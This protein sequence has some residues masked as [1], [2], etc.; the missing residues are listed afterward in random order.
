MVFLYTDE[1]SFIMIPRP[2]AISVLFAVSIA[3]A[4]T[5]SGFSFPSTKHT[6]FESLQIS[7]GLIASY[8]FDQPSGNILTDLSGNN[9]HGTLLNNPTWTTG[10]YD[11]ALNF[12]GVNDYVTIGDLDLPGSFTVSFWSTADNLGGGC[13]GSAVMKRND[14]GFEVCDGKMLAQVGT[15]TGGFN[16]ALAYQ[17]PQSGV[18]NYYALTYDGTTARFYV[19][20]N[21]TATT[22]KSHGSNNNPL[23]IGSWNTGSEFYDGLID[24]VRIYTRTLSQSE[25][26]SD[27]NSPVNTG[28]EV[29]TPHIADPIGGAQVSNIITVIAH[30]HSNVNIES[31]QFYVDGL[32]TGPEDATDPYAL[33]WDTREVANGSHTLTASAR[34]VNGNVGF[35]ETVTVNVVNANY[36]QNEILATGFNLPTSIEFLPD[37][38]ML[39]VELTGTIKILPHPYTQSNPTPFLQLNLNIGGYDG[40]QQGIYDLVL[41][42]DFSNNHY[43]YIFYTTGGQNRY[44]RLSR[45]TANSSITGTLPGSEVVLYQDPQ[46]ADTEHH[47]GS[48]N[49]GNDGKIYFTTG[50]HF[51]AAVAQL[52]S[53]PRGKIHRINSDGSVPTDNPF[54]DASGPNWDSI[55]ALGLRNPFRAYYDAP[56][57]R[58]LVADVGGNVYSTAKEEINLGIA[59]ANYG[60]P[61]SEGNCSS[62]C[63]SPIYFYPHNGRDASTSGGFVYHGAQFPSSY[64]DNYFFADY[65]QNWIRRLTFDQN[66]NVGG[67]YNFEPADGSLDG[68]YGDIVYLTEGPDGA[69]YYVDL[70]YSDVGGTF[71]ISKIRRIRYIETNQAP[72]AIA[73]GS[74]TAGP[75]PLLVNFSSVGSSDPE[76]ATLAY[77]WTF[78]DGTTSTEANPTHTYSQ[79]GQYTVRLSVSDGVNS[80]LAPPIFISAGNKPTGTILT[81]QDGSSFIAGQIITFSGSGTD[82]EDG[83]LPASAFTWNIDFLHE[84][85]AHPGLVMNGSKSGTFTIPTNGHD[86]S[87]NTRYRITLTITDSTG[88]QDIKSVIVYPNKVNLSFNTSPSGLTLYLDGIAH[89]APFVYDTLVG[90][91]HT[92]D[93]PNQ[94][95]YTFSSW[96]DGGS[97]THV[98][99]VP[100]QNTN[101]LASFNTFS[102]PTA[103][104][105]PTSTPT[106]TATATSTRTPTPS[107]TVTPTSTPTK[108]A[109]ATS[110]R[111]PTPTPALSAITIGETDILA[112]DDSG[113][114]SLLL[115]Q[116]TVLSQSATIQSMSFYVATV[117]GQLRLG[118]YNDAGGGPGTLLAQTAAF[119]PTTGWNTRNVVTPVL[120]P[121]GTYWL[122]Y[123]PESNNL[124]FR[125]TLTGSAKYYSYTFGTLPNTFSGSSTS[126]T[127][128]WSLYATLTT[129]TSPGAG[130]YDDTD[131][132]WTY[133]GTWITASGLTGPHANTFTYSGTAGNSASF[134]F[135]GTQFILKYLQ[136]INRGSIAIYVDGGYVATVNQNGPLEW[137]KTYTSPVYSSG[138]HTVRIDHIGGGPYVDIDA[139]V[140]Q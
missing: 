77:A 82:T 39:V 83:S 28:S 134:S 130:T 136:Y 59:G 119:T 96:S 58:L 60:W 32:P 75:I 55:W 22:V 132:G 127:V 73:T 38:R 6:S 107:A 41:D 67:V 117:G 8:S 133:T 48:I 30:V 79:A 64:Q 108:T 86:F 114:G 120:L 54:Y 124:H 131:G 112:S 2:I 72:I 99:T 78:G 135:T 118:I 125:K 95:P 56:T 90:Y 138:P 106:K 101:Y 98:I 44:D 1:R 52:L 24:E 89:T 137:Q 20:G 63:T 97:Q 116:Q 34:D 115:A 29:P 5:V 80:T 123:L 4:L 91:N 102:T 94:M 68:P 87:G 65:S 140:I 84:G 17:I 16:T 26:Q 33:T 3:L 7:S 81:P 13:H 23:L 15:G 139:I 110:T 37:G 19:N 126:A 31:V 113:N 104:V 25:I 45:F 43:Y 74:P 18:W 61:N 71:G 88:L 53:S 100:A 92:I 111:T 14:Y 70:G 50:D 129:E 40:L 128:H 66:G 76:G 27:M 105:T 69:I 109:T 103:T 62:P 85:H 10:K 51:N 57:S 11:N 49:F 47:G 21:L 93:A 9:N 122:A 121:A 35:S 42:P 12:D 36:F 46:V